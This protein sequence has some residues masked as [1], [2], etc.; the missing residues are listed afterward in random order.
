[1]QDVAGEY[2]EA[3]AYRRVRTQ[4]TRT[5]E[6]L[7]ELDDDEARAVVRSISARPHLVAYYRQS[8]WRARS[9]VLQTVLA[10]P[11]GDGR[12]TTGGG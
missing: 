8:R 9:V 1:M 7:G 2:F 11:D 5:V 10:S 12:D 3:D 6:W 4:Y